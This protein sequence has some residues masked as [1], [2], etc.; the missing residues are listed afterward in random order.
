MSTIPFPSK[1]V[2]VPR[3]LPD[4][5]S[6]EEFVE[7]AEGL[8]V[9]DII[10]AYDANDRSFTYTRTQADQFDAML[11][12][13]MNLAASIWDLTNPDMSAPLGHTASNDPSASADGSSTSR[14]TMT[15]TDDALIASG[16]GLILP[17]SRS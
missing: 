12:S 11:Y 14:L 1:T 2:H 8:I 5:M 13:I 15:E 10:S 4:D 16:P 6:Y 7:L 17:F 3:N 9:A